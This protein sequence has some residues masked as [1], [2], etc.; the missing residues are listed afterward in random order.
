MVFIFGYFAVSCLVA[1][2]VTCIID[3][4]L[5]HG[6]AHFFSLWFCNFFF[7]YSN[8]FYFF[9][10]FVS[11]FGTRKSK[12]LIR[13]VK[14]YVQTHITKSPCCTFPI[15]CIMQSQSIRPRKY[16][17]SNSQVKLPGKNTWTYLNNSRSFVS[18]KPYLYTP[19]KY[20][21]FTYSV[22]CFIEI[23]PT[24]WTSNTLAP[25]VPHTKGF[26]FKFPEFDSLSG[27]TLFVKLLRN[28]RSWILS[29]TSNRCSNSS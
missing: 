22:V 24:Q 29:Q 15:D 7:K 26:D 10:F 11:S 27:N 21:K 1:L 5:W 20:M 16:T 9:K 13:R 18:P 14:N 23:W 8:T 2:W 6:I 4:L 28:K 25:E 3:L 12:M 17:L 19:E